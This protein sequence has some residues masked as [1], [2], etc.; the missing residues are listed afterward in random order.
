MDHSS[1]HSRWSAHLYGTP[2]MRP[3]DIRVESDIKL[4]WCMWP[5]LFEWRSCFYMT[6][7]S[8]FETIYHLV[9][10]GLGPFLTLSVKGCQ[11]SQEN[12]AMLTVTF[13]DRLVSLLSNLWIYWL[14]I[15]LVRITWLTLTETYVINKVPLIFFFFNIG[16]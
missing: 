8:L 16:T 11:D 5:H 9:Q 10:L 4:C 12:L 2:H 6:P 3:V 1:C 15:S 13:C 7:F 14:T